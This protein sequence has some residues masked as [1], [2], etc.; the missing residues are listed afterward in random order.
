MPFLIAPLERAGLPGSKPISLEQPTRFEKRPFIIGQAPGAW[1]LAIEPHRRNESPEPVACPDPEDVLVQAY[2]SKP[3]ALG[4]GTGPS[5][6]RRQEQGP[7]S[8]Q[9]RHPSS[10]GQSPYAQ[11]RTTPHSRSAR[12]GAHS[13]MSRS[14][15]FSDMMPR[16]SMYA[17]GGGADP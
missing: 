14:W 8:S 9:A 2:V 3:G 4:P 16:R 17:N 12:Q 7:L 11:P 15:P 6:T 1:L 5:T 10:P 13:A